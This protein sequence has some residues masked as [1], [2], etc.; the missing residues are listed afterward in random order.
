MCGNRGYGSSGVEKWHSALA[1]VILKDLSIL[2]LDEAATSLDSE[3]DVLIM[4]AFKW[5]VAGWKSIVIAYRVST[6]LAEDQILVPDRG[7]IV[8][9]GTQANLLSKGA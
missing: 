4:E 9:R 1:R 5:L 3:S 6:I 7:I 2:V 8:E